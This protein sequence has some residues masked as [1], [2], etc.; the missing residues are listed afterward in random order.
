MTALRPAQLSV[1]LPYSRTLKALTR[2]AMDEQA[3]KRVSEP[4][5]AVRVRWG[6]HYEPSVTAV[7]LLPHSESTR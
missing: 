2:P 5:F 7:R 1:P 3:E 6:S 4:R